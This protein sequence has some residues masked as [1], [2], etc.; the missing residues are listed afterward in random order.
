MLSGTPAASKLQT[1]F[2]FLFSLHEGFGGAVS[3][4]NKFWGMPIIVDPRT[5]MN[6]GKTIRTLQL[7]FI[8]IGEIQAQ[9]QW[10]VYSLLDFMAMGLTPLVSTPLNC[11]LCFPLP[12][13]ILLP[14]KQDLCFLATALLT[15]R[16]MEFWF[17]LIFLLSNMPV[18]FLHPLASLSSWPQAFHSQHA[19]YFRQGSWDNTE[20]AGLVFHRPV[21]LSLSFWKQVGDFWCFWVER[22]KSCVEI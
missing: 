20:Y 3:W 19:I 18:V 7:A 11:S 17:R 14:W 1:R 2:N 16:G 8:C 4:P 10:N 6:T 22:L 13:I 12:Q 5:L 21:F 15:V 9:Q